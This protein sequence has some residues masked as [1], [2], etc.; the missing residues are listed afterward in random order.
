M[1]LAELASIDLTKIPTDAL[2]AM[3]TAMHKELSYRR[4][5]IQVSDRKHRMSESEKFKRLPNEKHLHNQHHLKF[6]DELM[7][8]DWSHLF[9]GDEEKRYYVYAHISPIGKRITHNGEFKLSM[10]GIPFYIGKGT[11]GRAF[12]LKRNQGH[13]IEI[14]QLL[15]RGNTASQIVCI[16]RDNLSEA[17]ALEIESKLIYFFGTKFEGHRRGLL[18][19]LDIPPTPFK[20]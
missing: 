1:K 19:N 12:D 18:V 16:V 14:A 15:A 8:Q 20:R 5:C 3:Y 2:Q 17:E 6:L 13:G 4:A 10:D 9:T 11:G 7:A